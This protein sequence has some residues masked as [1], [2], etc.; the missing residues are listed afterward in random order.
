MSKIAL[1]I[2]AISRIDVALVAELR[3]C[4]LDELSAQIGSKGAMQTYL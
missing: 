2:H 3:A 1:A 4:Y